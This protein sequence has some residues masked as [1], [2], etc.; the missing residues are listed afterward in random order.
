M[1]SNFEVTVIVKVLGER[2]KLEKTIESLVSQTLPFQ[3]CIQMILWTGSE[4]AGP[5]NVCSKYEALYPYNIKV[6]E[7]LDL[8][9]AYGQ[10][11]NY[12]QEGQ[13]W[14]PQA[15]EE[16]QK[17][18][19]GTA[20][21][22]S[23]IVEDYRKPEEKEELK[24]HYDYAINHS[25]RFR[26]EIGMYLFGREFDEYLER[27]AAAS[28]KLEQIL[29]LAEIILKSEQIGILENVKLFGKR[30]QYPVK[31]KAWY[32]MELPDFGRHMK[33]L[34]ERAG[35][36]HRNQ[37][38]FIYMY[39]LSEAMKDDTEKVLNEKELEEFQKWLKAELENLSD[40]VICRANMNG[41]T[42]RFALSLKYGRDIAE[43]LK[44]RNGKMFFGNYFIY[45]LKRNQ[46]F[47]IT[48]AEQRGDLLFLTALAVIPLPL[49]MLEFY[50]WD[51]KQEYAFYYRSEGNTVQ[52]CLQYIIGRET[53]YECTLPIA[54]RQAEFQLYCRYRKIYP[55]L[56]EQNCR[57][58]INAGDKNE[59]KF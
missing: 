34:A 13:C 52:K 56:L 11:V 45:N 40:T 15:F 39:Q 23:F 21:E 2:K 12:I 49:K 47:R 9:A 37:L 22:I 54:I 3:R 53:E 16:A 46:S 59:K 20:G 8:S 35:R 32:Q 5:A 27:L 14:A 43:E 29:V 31:T 48:G 50:L 57:T 33:M 17:L 6:Q 18:Y 41:G 24:N 26:E 19:R 7:K 58:I 10:Y 30:T 28:R 4:G 36:E 38:E 51:G 44:L 25:Q 42:R 55:V 1:D